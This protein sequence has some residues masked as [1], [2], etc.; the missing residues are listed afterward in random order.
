MALLSRILVVAALLSVPALAQAKSQIRTPG[1]FGIGLG[2][3][4]ASGISAKYF[5]GESTSVQA[6]LGTFGALEGE[7]NIDGFAVGGDFL[8]EMPE[9]F[10]HPNIELAWSVGGGVGL[11]LV[12]TAFDDELSISVQGVL[13]FQVHLVP[14]PIDIVLEFRPELRL[15]EDADFDLIDLGAHVRYYF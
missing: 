8:F 11:A 2:S 10:R 6:T 15:V 1:K 7:G 9:F 4:Y 13:G 12:D 3:G 5:L 14:V